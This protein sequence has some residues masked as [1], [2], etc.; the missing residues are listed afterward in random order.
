ML[1]WLL[2]NTILACG[3]ALIA[4]LV[5]RRMPARPAVGHV[6]WL[7]VLVVLVLPP[8]ALK[9]PVAVRGILS[10]HIEG[11]E[12]AA[13]AR[14]ERTD[15]G[16][17][18]E[19]EFAPDGSLAALAHTAEAFAPADSPVARSPQQI[20][21]VPTFRLSPMTEGRPGPGSPAAAESGTWIVP[22][23][24]RSAIRVL[25][26]GGA[27]VVLTLFLFRV[28][29]I[30]RWVRRAEPA[31]LD[32]V[33]QIRAIAADL[34]VRAPDAR[35]LR[36]V[37]T[38]MVWGLGRPVL[39]WP[40][41]LATSGDGFRGLL[42]HELAHLRRRDHWLAFFQ[43][44]VTA[45]LW[46]HPLA[47]VAISRMDRFAEQ[48]CDAW[49]VRAVAG[50]RRDYAEALIGVV[51]RLSLG[52]QSRTGLAA[53]GQGRRALAD[54]IGI[55]MRPDASPSCSKPIL[56]GAIALLAL[57]VPSFAPAQHETRETQPTAPFVMDARLEGLAE[58]AALERQAHEWFEAREWERAAERYEAL[59]K[60]D[61][62]DQDARARY[63]IAL[64]HTDR[65]E[66][67]EAALRAVLGASDAEARFWLAGVLSAEGRLDESRAMLRTALEHGLDFE[68][69]LRS[70][71][72]FA[73][74][75]D[76]EASARLLAD[77]TR[78]HELRKSARASM[79]ERDTG[80]AI[81]A[82][83]ELS[84]LA[85]SDGSTWHFLSYARIAAGDYDNA[86]VALDRQQALGH[87]EDVAEYN[88]ACVLAL[89]GQTV[90]AIAALSRAVDCGFDDYELARK[91]PDLASLRT[92]PALEPVMERL[93]RPARLLKEMEIAREFGEWARVIEVCEDL[94]NEGSEKRRRWLRTEK[95]L[96]LAETG[97]TDSAADELIAAMV[98]G[99]PAGEGLY[100][101]A[102]VQAMAGDESR[103][104][105]YLVAA[106]EAG[107][108][109]LE[110]AGADQRLAGLADDAT[111]RDAAICV[112]ERRE[113]AWFRVA[114]WA[115]L[116]E[117]AR[118]TL[119]R[120][121][122]A[123]QS[124][125]ELGWAMLRLKR[126][127]DAEP[128]FKSLA[129]SGW[130]VGPS[131]YNVACCA[132]LSGRAD[133]AFAWLERAAEAGMTNEHLYLT[134]RDLKN[135]REDPRFEAMM[136]RLRG[137]E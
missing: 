26:L 72:V 78:V 16:L 21:E 2:E 53:G 135:L 98:D 35:V 91:D 14:L 90:P 68:R 54:R 99:F 23:A 31:P 116:E 1:G 129:E 4:M 47:R 36:G 69:R 45:L 107:F 56:L 94:T 3:I 123:A 112:V 87:R 105:G 59:L 76:D 132:A 33:V 46:W 79:Q 34:G 128:I 63:G 92:E 120:E 61:A 67:A 93:V 15:P 95:A 9:S 51:E 101:L 50:R 133:D 44:M 114:S 24:A 20:V 40:A 10:P 110:R 83:E 104:L 80:A 65:L 6:M 96:A 29:R 85:P 106:V 119:E 75:R 126:Y 8:I 49:A 66:E 115:A 74:L 37:A 57:L 17:G 113:L 137:G 109:D 12:A 18:W 7:T 27:V 19:N 103:A 48:A 118:A 60:I 136:E 77:A 100:R 70:E 108:D 117:R 25:W 102:R 13:W 82:L 64:M 42:A 124:R 86:I 134:D 32:L 97:E 28:R 11:L 52:R 43:V 22:L 39:L 88:R 127:D 130:N 122:E 111:V 71:P 81:A 121:P 89:R 125:H 55:V 5:E 41:E 131:R 73:A 30:D 62:D 84:T 58:A 38:P